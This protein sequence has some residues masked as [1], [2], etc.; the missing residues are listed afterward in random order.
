MY[1]LCCLE[2]EGECFYNGGEGRKQA[3]F[4]VGVPP[5]LSTYLA[6]FVRC[7]N[8]ILIMPTRH[9]SFLAPRR[10]GRH[11]PDPALAPRVWVLQPQPR[12]SQGPR[13]TARGP[14]APAGSQGPEKSCSSGPGLDQRGGEGERSWPTAAGRREGRVPRQSRR[15]PG[16]TGRRLSLDCSAGFREWVRRWPDLPGP[17]GPR[18]RPPAPRPLAPRRA[19]DPRHDPGGPSRLPSARPAPPEPGVLHIGRAR[20][21]SRQPCGP[22]RSG[23]PRARPVASPTCGPPPTRPPPPT[24]SPPARLPAPGSARSRP[25]LTC[26]APRPLAHRPDRLC[27]PEVTSLCRPRPR[28]RRTPNG[29]ALSGWQPTLPHPLRERGGGGPAPSTLGTE[30]LQVGQPGWG[31]RTRGQSLQ[32]HPRPPVRLGLWAEGISCVLTDLLSKL[33][34]EKLSAC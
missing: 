3:I 2:C 15:T 4:K 16:L 21:G 34:T 25:L 11:T 31:L 24:P 22:E 20:G 13:R 7:I 27:T 19:P 28:P 9:A 29:C 33:I 8:K 1:F 12:P 26:D 10:A 17:G 6:K 14:T 23:A 32:G 5:K 30:D 18:E